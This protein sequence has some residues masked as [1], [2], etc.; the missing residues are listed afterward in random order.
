MI[1]AEIKGQRERDV[2]NQE[3]KEGRYAESLWG[4][5]ECGSLVEQRE[6]HWAGAEWV[7]RDEVKD[8]LRA[9]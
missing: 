4:G 9:L 3:M 6:G 2:N 1:E 7:F 8:V 5:E